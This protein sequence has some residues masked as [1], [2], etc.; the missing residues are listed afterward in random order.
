[1]QS[2]GIFK[3]LLITFCLA[4]V[5]YGLMFGCD[6]HLRSRK[7]AWELTFASS[8]EGEPVLTVDQPYH[9]ISK[10][11]MVFKGE[12][13]LGPTKR[14]RFDGPGVSLPFGQPI[15]FDTTYLPGSITL[16]LFGHQVEILPRTL[17]LNFEERPWVEGELIELRPEESLASKATLET[18]QP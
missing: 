15:F 3:P 9:G 7:G 1:M 2:D 18:T 4:L 17:I 11:R 16:D 5:G 6:R 13:F 8:T 14:L 12:S 10:V